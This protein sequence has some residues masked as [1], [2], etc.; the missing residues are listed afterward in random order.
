MSFTGPESALKTF[1]PKGRFLHSNQE[2]TV[3]REAGQA[4]YKLGKFRVSSPMTL[5]ILGLYETDTKLYI[6]KTLCRSGLGS[7]GSRFIKLSSL[8]TFDQF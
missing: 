1:I 5:H 7:F 4:R 8:I 6:K 3:T 2:V